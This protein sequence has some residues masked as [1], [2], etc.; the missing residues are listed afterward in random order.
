MRIRKKSLAVGLLIA[1]FIYTTA[2]FLLVPAIALH[3]INSQ[4]SRLATVPAQLGRVEFNPFSMQSTLWDLQIGDPDA[5][6]ISFQRLYVN[7]ELDSLWTGALHLA[8]VELDA[9]HGEVHFAKDGT[10]NLAKLFNLPEADAAAS[11][12]TSQ[13]L[14]PLRIDRVALN[15]NSLHFIDERT[16]TAV[17][18]AYDDLSLELKNLSTRPDE[19]TAITLNASGPNGARLAWQGNATLA[20]NIT[21]SGSLSIQ[22]AQLST[23][24]PYIRDQF[25]LDLDSG[26]LSASTEYQLDLSEQTDFRLQNA[27]LALTTLSIDANGKPRLR[28]PS[29][30]V[31]DSALNLAKREVV[32]GQ[33]HSSELE[34]WA[35]REQNGTIDL[36]ALLDSKP[37]ASANQAETSTPEPSQQSTRQTQAADVTDSTQQVA[38]PAP[39]PATAA[40]TPATQ[41]PPWRVQLKDATLD[42]SQ[43]HLVDRVPSKPVALEVGP[44]DISISQFDSLGTTPFSVQLTTGLNNN[45]QLS[46]SGQVQLKPLSA[47]LKAS[48]RNIDLRLARPYFEPLVRIQLRSGLANS[49]LNINLNGLEPLA[50]E[51]SGDAQVSQ[52]HIIDA[53]RERDLLKWQQLELSSIDYQGNSLTINKVALQQPYVRFIINENL[54][55]NFSGLLVE[56]PGTSQKQSSS[57]PMAIRI[58]GVTIADGSANFADFSLQ[59]DFSAA[60]GQLN[61]DIGTLDNQSTKPAS[62]NV[63]GKIDRYAPVSIKGS[64][65]PF[66]P[67]NSLDIATTF[68]NVELTT[69]TPY[70]GK[71]AGYRIRK[72]R[73]NLDLHYRIEQGQLNAEN[74]VLLEGLQLGEK[75]DSPDAVDLPVR[76]AIALLKD[77]KGNI[78]IQLPVA[79]NLADPQFSVM[80]I[81]WQTLRNLVGRAAQAPFKF[82]AGLVGG[83]E[84]DLSEVSFTAGRETLGS[85]AEATLT[86]LASALQQRPALTLEVEGVSSAAVDG[87]QLASERLVREYQR[88]QFKS[89]QAMGEQ[90]PASRELIEV[91]DE[92]KPALLEGI[93]R[94]RLKQQPP[95]EWSQLNQEERA[96]KMEQ[97]LLDLWSHS[98]LMLRKLAQRRAAAIKSYLVDAGGLDPERVYLIDVSITEQA[99]DGHVASALHLGS[100]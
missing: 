80:P 60:I 41:S 72:G 51:V 96:A 32:I 52:L 58:G 49:D 12:D 83:N 4:L 33:L 99:S 16:Q 45:G 90:V 88:L 14:F 37:Q 98:N 23:L 22:D 93:Y 40:Q 29:L 1:S 38:N 77:S 35:A 79:G 63:T 87:P 24:W 81:I 78:D 69:L 91:D 3:T 7:A 46:A 89:L 47:T 55:T 8:D 42:G 76:L 48:T 62:V 86:T 54:T 34:A 6:D 39:S 18:F 50:L 70:S 5:P 71:F 68:R 75:V 73:L 97:A 59:P 27:Q 94:A 17:E 11:D 26:A 85:G 82:I 44:L 65:T 61:G 28:L 13:A 20:P 15:K 56:Q 64:L 92:D 25:D 74:K 36:L 2:G 95:E 9:A 67:L 30:T 100:E 66:D 31:S 57:A 19:T 10:L 43:L 84:Q 21:S 53:E